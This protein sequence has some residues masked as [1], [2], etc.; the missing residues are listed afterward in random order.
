MPKWKDYL[1]HAKERG[2]LAFELF[3]TVSTPTGDGER[4]QATLPA[5]LAYLAAQ[6]S[7]GTLV[8]AG[9]LSDE[10][11]EEMQGMGMLIWRAASFEEAKALAANDPMHIS[12][13]RTFTLRRW[14][15]NEGSFGVKVDLGGQNVAL[16]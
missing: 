14:M 15:I 10:T 2:S 6:E 7:A 5:H 8:F 16:S 12:G 4:L 9:P 11:G 1:A 13:A 3:C